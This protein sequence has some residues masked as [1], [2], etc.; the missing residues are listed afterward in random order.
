LA[1]FPPKC[2]TQN[3]K[4]LE[5]QKKNDLFL[6]LSHVI[7]HS[8]CCYAARKNKMDLL[9]VPFLVKKRNSPIFGHFFPSMRPESKKFP[10]KT[11]FIISGSCTEKHSTLV[12]D[13]RLVEIN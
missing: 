3:F 7:I 5:K 9:T 13:E 8:A 4:C 10:Q 2:S 6:T 11:F 1:I 12:K